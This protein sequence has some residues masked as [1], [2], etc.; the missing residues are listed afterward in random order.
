MTDDLQA[1]IAAEV[2]RISQ[3]ALEEQPAEFN[4]LRERLEKALNETAAPSDQ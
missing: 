4:A 3:L 2:E 1:E